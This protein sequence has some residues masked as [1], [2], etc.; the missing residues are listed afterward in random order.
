MDVEAAE[1]RRFEDG[2][3]KDETV[4]NDDRGVGF[5]AR[6]TRLDLPLDLRERGVRTGIPTAVARAWTG[7]G[8][9]FMP[10][11]AGRGGWE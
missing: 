4:G 9:S 3:G 1:A 5:K 2:A 11:P 7:D 10:R 6:Q 8:R